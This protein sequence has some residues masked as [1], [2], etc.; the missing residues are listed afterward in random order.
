MER[1]PPDVILRRMSLFYFALLTATTLSACGDTS[2]PLVI[3]RV[4]VTE[5]KTTC[6][7]PKESSAEL[8]DGQYTQRITFMHRPEKLVGHG[9][10]N[11]YEL[12]CDVVLDPNQPVQP[13]TFSVP[14]DDQL[15]QIAIRVEAF[16][17]TSLVYAGQ[18]DEVNLRDTSATILLHRANAQ[19]CDYQ[20]QHVRAFH[21]STLLPNGQVLVVGG[22]AGRPGSETILSD[23]IPGQ[24]IVEVFDTRTLAWSTVTGSVPPRAFHA[25]LLLPSPAEGPY[26]ILLI[27]GLFAE[28]ATTPLAHPLAAGR[29][30]VI[31]PDEQA[32]PGELA[33][34]TYNPGSESK[35]PSVMYSAIEGP[36]SLFPGVAISADGTRLLVTGGAESYVANGATKGFATTSTKRTHTIDLTTEIP[37]TIRS[38]TS[39]RVRV[40]HQVARLESGLYVAIGGN[41]DGDE[42]TLTT[43]LADLDNL[44]DPP[45]TTSLEVQSSAPAFASLTPIGITDQDLKNDSPA[46]SLLWAGGFS[47]SRGETPFFRFAQQLQTNPLYLVRRES[48][49]TLKASTN[50]G[51]DLFVPAGYHAAIRLAD[52][53]VL[54]SGGNRASAQCIL[55]N[56][57]QRQTAFC[58]NEQLVVYRLDA[59]TLISDAGQLSLKTPRFGHTATRLLDQQVLFVGGLSVNNDTQIEVT[60]AAEIYSPRTGVAA[61]DTPFQREPGVSRKPCPDEDGNIAHHAQS[62]TVT[63]N[64]LT[65]PS[66]TIGSRLTK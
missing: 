24:P 64:M 53:S 22:L 15:D 39:L 19:S 44:T 37:N 18:T 14:V 65:S 55:P 36:A 61:E 29:P 63:T 23:N 6:G 62:L 43:Q 48:N 25:A 45:S 11:D 47:L 16:D 54:L 7:N 13:S 59:N 9:N 5:A 38:D 66:L 41:M 35:V 46:P 20:S 56:G 28:K 1:Y 42:Q 26:R 49:T 4:L 50:D 17:G 52:G 21:T 57:S 10:I 32:Q 33:L 34:L 27:G 60:N 12:V 3:R 40:G 2:P 30:F 8:P 58:P 51:Q 31:T